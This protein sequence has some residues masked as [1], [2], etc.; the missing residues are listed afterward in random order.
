MA[1][2]MNGQKIDV[3]DKDENLPPLIIPNKTA[4][5]ETI[6]NYVP[7]KYIPGV[8]GRPPLYESKAQN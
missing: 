2:A 8:R 4:G 6:K 1:M 5:V 3:P 7:N